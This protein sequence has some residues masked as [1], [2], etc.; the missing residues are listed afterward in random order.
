[1]PSF[2][3]SDSDVG[4]DVARRSFCNYEE[5]EGERLDPSMANDF[6]DHMAR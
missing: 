2:W 6:K 3:V 4:E 5:A 1:M